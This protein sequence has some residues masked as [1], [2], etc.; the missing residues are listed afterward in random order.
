MK[1]LDWSCKIG[2]D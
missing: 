1:K 2:L